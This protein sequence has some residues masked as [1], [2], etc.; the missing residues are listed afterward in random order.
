MVITI[1]M[2]NVILR[3]GTY[4]FRIK[5]P[6]DCQGSVGKTE[7]TQSLKTKEA[8][9]AD[10]LANGLTEDWKKKFEDIRNPASS[11]ALAI[12][13]KTNETV[14]DF[15][16]TLFAYM[17]KNLSAF[18]DKKS[19][20]ELY[21]LSGLYQEQMSSVGKNE[22]GSLDFSETLGIQWPLSKQH[23][24]GMTR[25]LNRVIVDALGQIRSAI[26]D[27]SGDD[28]SRQID[29]DL[30]DADARMFATQERTTSSPT[31]PDE[32]DIGEVAKLML[33]A[34]NTEHKYREFIEAEAKYLQEWLK[35]KAEITTFTK[36]DLVDYARNCLPYFPK[37]F[38]R[39]PAYK[40]KSLHQCVKLTNKNPDK[41]V[42]ISYR[43]AQNR[44][45]ALQVVFNYAKEQLG[46]IA[47]NPA[48]GVQIPQVR[49]QEKKPRGLSKTELTK[50]WAALKQVSESANKRPERYW[51]PILGL[52]HGFRLLGSLS[53][54]MLISH[55]LA[56]VC[57]S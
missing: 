27:E 1:T 5:V 51:I 30:M 45:A 53:G 20:E 7:I 39:K 50:M 54:S 48:T 49:V 2:K 4:H 11:P 46:I 24:P 19:E 43:T 55:L 52:Y 37:D 14:D 33:D 29:D 25:K 47:T 31:S 23:S 56:R 44:M 42:P 26:D 13:S 34:K 41:Y 22:M 16:K 32:M 6:K 12:Q 9:E 15:R 57:L 36:R 17:N 38:L 40:N 18:L 8:S 21:E 10:R 3:S 28:I 35:G